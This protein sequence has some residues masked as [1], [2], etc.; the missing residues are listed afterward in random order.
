PAGRVRRLG[1]IRAVFGFG[2]ECLGFECGRA[3]MTRRQS[4]RAEG[5]GVVHQSLQPYACLGMTPTISRDDV[6]AFMAFSE[7]E[8]ENVAKLVRSAGD[9]ER[10]MVGLYVGARVARK[11][12]PLERY[13]ALASMLRT[14][15]YDIAFVGAPSDV[16]AARE[17]ERLAQLDRATVWCDG[18]SIR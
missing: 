8:R 4:E 12:W 9:P 15:G 14:A 7:A 2:P 18:T 6:L 5:L 16:N 17:V 1:I 3:L 11:Q 13:A 10:G